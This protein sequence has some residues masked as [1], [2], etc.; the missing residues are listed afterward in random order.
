MLKVETYDGDTLKESKT[1]EPTV[2]RGFSST[3]KTVD[4][5]MTSVAMTKADMAAAAFAG[6]LSG[7]I[8]EINAVLAAYGHHRR[9]AARVAA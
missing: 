4:M 8:P 6:M 2:D 7:N 5:A 1:V 3:L 9:G